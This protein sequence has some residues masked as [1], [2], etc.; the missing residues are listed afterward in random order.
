[1]RTMIVRLHYDFPIEPRITQKKMAVA[2]RKERKTDAS[3][4]KVL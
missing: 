2:E 4:V 1:M 3:F